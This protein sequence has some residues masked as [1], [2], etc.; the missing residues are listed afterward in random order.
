MSKLKRKG[1][2]NGIDPATFTEF[3]SDSQIKIQ[4]TVTIVKCRLSILS[5]ETTP[6]Q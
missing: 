3:A 4:Q 6:A 2:E 5:R 1:P